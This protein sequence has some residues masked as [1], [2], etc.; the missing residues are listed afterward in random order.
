LV[1]KSARNGSRQET[2]RESISTS[3]HAH[4]RDGRGDSEAGS[5]AGDTSSGAGHRDDGQYEEAF[6][7]MKKAA[8]VSDVDEV[9]R[10][11]ETQ[12][13]TSKHLQVRQI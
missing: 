1:K 13:E 9:V 8:G 4:S 7:K 6:A 11:F 10:R 5:T 2:G 3:D 12:G